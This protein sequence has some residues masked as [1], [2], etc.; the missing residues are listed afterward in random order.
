MATLRDAGRL[1]EELQ[2]LAGR[3]N[4]ELTE[5][6]GDFG[7]LSS[8]ADNLGEAADNVAATFTQLDEILNER[9]LGQVSEET[10]TSGRRRRAGQA[11]GKMEDLSKDD[12]L[13]RAR[14]A[15]IAG[16]SGMSKKEL[17]D[18]LRTEGS[19]S[20][21]DLLERARDAELPGRS[22][23]SKAELRDALQSA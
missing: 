22:D 1:T 19:L 2:E 7:S 10:S 13:E 15:G 12:L 9:L 18:A 4:T 6:D 3:L 16:R 17:K 20:K 11:R 14:K 8:L 23:M 5:G 21:E